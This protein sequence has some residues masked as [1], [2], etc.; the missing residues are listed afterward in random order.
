MVE[1]IDLK[2]VFTNAFTGKR[3]CLH[4]NRTDEGEDDALLKCYEMSIIN[5]TSRCCVACM[6]HG[7]ATQTIRLGAPRWAALEE[8][9]SWTATLMKAYYWL[10]SSECC[11]FCVSVCLFVCLLVCLLVCLFVSVFSLARLVSL[12]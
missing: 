11:W 1:K 4:R 2:L 12:Q 6:G 8:S 7:L 10:M 5:N 3:L 9:A